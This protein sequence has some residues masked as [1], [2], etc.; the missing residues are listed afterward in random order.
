MH[1]LKCVSVVAA[2]LLLCLAGTAGAQLFD[3]AGN[4]LRLC[5]PGIDAGQACTMDTMCD[6]S[7]NGDMLG[8][9]SELKIATFA[10]TLDDPD[11]YAINNQFFDA[12]NQTTMYAWFDLDGLNF[13]AG[14]ARRT[15][16]IS[17]ASVRADFQWVIG[18]PT[19]VRQKDKRNIVSQSS[20]V[21][22]LLAFSTLVPPTTPGG[23]TTIV[24]LFRITDPEN[25]ALPTP[26]E[27]CKARVVVREPT[28]ASN[29]VPLSDIDLDATWRLDCKDLPMPDGLACIDGTED[30]PPEKQVTSEDLLK[31]FEGSKDKVKARGKED[32]PYCDSWITGPTKPASCD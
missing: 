16:E 21:A 6:L 1:L 30:C 15:E 20:Y 5:G 2:S 9:C 18:V 24:P 12:K 10:P 14:R 3:S 11:V 32:V 27:T 23:S 4:P 25:T 28:K 17:D 19:K 7:V 22:I 13:A 31:Y 8:K 29:E 26:I